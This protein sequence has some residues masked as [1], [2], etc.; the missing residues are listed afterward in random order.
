MISP[1]F[2]SSIWIKQRP[3]Q[4]TNLAVLKNYNL[5]KTKSYHWPH[6]CQCHSFNGVSQ[7]AKNLQSLPNLFYI[8]YTG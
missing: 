4:L 6:P 1:L 5:S 3:L 7:M 8:V 2:T